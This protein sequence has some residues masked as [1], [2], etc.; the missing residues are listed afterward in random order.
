MTGISNY[1]LEIEI[2]ILKSG[3]LSNEQL[4]AAGLVA[5]QKERLWVRHRLADGSASPY[6][7]CPL[8]NLRHCLAED[9]E[10]D[11]SIKEKLPNIER[12]AICKR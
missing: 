1:I 9:R 5:Y 8:G 12:E 11:D 3:V 6:A 2:Y 10:I 7:A 4:E